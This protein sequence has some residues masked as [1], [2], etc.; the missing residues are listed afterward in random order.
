MKTAL[1][2][3]G[4][5]HLCFQQHQNK[6]YLGIYRGSIIGSPIVLYPFRKGWKVAKRYCKLYNVQL[7]VN[8]CLFTGYYK[9]FRRMYKTLPMA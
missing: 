8:W 1:Q 9:S 7:S 4:D 6:I 2:S 5:M 3:F